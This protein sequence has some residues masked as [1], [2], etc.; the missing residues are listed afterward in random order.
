MAGCYLVVLEPV[1]DERGAFTRAFSSSELE[2]AGLEGHISQINISR[3]NVAG[4][5]RGIH[6]QEEPYA[7]AKL[8]RCTRGRVFDVCVDVREGSPTWG[9]WVGIE[10]TPESDLALYV[11]AG[12]GHGYQA[13]ESGSELTYSSSSPYAPESEQGARWD[14]SAFDIEWPINTD[15]IIS[16]KDQGWPP[17]EAV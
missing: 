15:L 5:I 14:D 4:T 13:L 8:A 6:W 17:I 3:S 11:P 10:L 1:T 12:C 9:L 7:E 2:E 16:E